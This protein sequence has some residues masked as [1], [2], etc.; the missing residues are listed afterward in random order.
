MTKAPALLPEGLRDRLPA[1][2]EA[3]SRVTRALVDAM[4]AHGYG[5]VQP[6][7]AEFRETLGGDDDRTARDL[8][9]FTDPVSQRTLALRPD[10][11]RQV[12]RIATSLLGGAP[13]PLRLCYAGQVVKLRASQ[14]R[15]ARCCKSAPS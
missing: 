8:L 7:L 14:L 13:R 11:T 9:R 10:I 6:P 3:A 12:G 4:R 5:R 1:Q 15:P 2:A